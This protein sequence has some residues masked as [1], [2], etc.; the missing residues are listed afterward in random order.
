MGEKFSIYFHTFLTHTQ[1][2]QNHIVNQNDN[3]GFIFGHTNHGQGV[4]HRR[5]KYKVKQ[6]VRIVSTQ[7]SIK[8]QG[9]K[10]LLKS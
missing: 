9:K 10:R 4:R 6:N 8:R 7:H 3:D 1:H 2:A 5:G